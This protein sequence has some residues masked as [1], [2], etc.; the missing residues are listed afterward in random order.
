MDKN[1]RATWIRITGQLDKNMQLEGLPEL[2]EKLSSYNGPT[3]NIVNFQDVIARGENPTLPHHQ[4]TY[5]HKTSGG[6]EENCY[7]EFDLERANL[8]RDYYVDIGEC[9]AFGL[10][11]ARGG[12]WLGGLTFAACGTFNAIRYILAEQDLY[13]E[14]DRCLMECE[15]EAAADGSN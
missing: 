13:D 8:W 5:T 11:G 9:V 2:I 3:L 12:P 15:I 1:C 10:I 4:Y 6:C 7:G 14:L